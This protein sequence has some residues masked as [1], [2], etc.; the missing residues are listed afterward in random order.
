M[1]RKILFASLLLASGG[2]VLIN[3]CSK[4]E[5]S[6]TTNPVITLN[7]SSSVD[8]VLNGSYTDAGA[9][10]TDDKDGGVSVTTNNP[11]NV[12]SAASYTVTYSATDAAGN[13]ATSSRTVIVANGSAGLAGTYTTIEN[14]TDTFTQ[15]I[16]ASSS[17]NNRIFFSKFANYSSNSNIYV[18]VIGTA[19]DLQTQNGVGIGASGCDHTF[20][21]NG[22]GN[23]I[24]QV[25]GKYTFSV[26]FTDAEL[27]GAGGCQ[28]TNPVAFEDL[29]IQQ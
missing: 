18:N 27:A 2:L 22:S 20:A 10:A 21:P 25:L 11:V 14:A 9:T 15:T 23:S 26:K 28:S 5:D 24:T 4:S 29:F 16:T 7:G 12:D 6:D 8:V 17:I 19:L 13:T 3:G 1:K